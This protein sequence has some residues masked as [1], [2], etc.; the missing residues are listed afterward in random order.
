MTSFPDEQPLTRR[1][2]RERLRAQQAHDG[3][4][5]PKS[6]D[7]D[8]APDDDT[9]HNAG[10]DQSHRLSGSVRDSE[11]QVEPE[12]DAPDG[13]G[14]PL[15][16][17][18]ARAQARASS[19]DAQRSDSTKISSAK[20]TSSVDREE[21]RS[22]EEP[23]ENRDNPATEED[24]S[25]AAFGQK[26][27]NKAPAQAFESLIAPE[28]RPSDALTTSSALVLPGAARKDDSTPTTGD[29]LVTGSVD[30]HR[31][32]EREA[33]SGKGERL[34]TDD[35]ADNGPEANQTAGTPVSA[36]KAVSTHSVTRDVITPQTKTSSSKLLMILA[37]TAGV[38]CVA[39]IGVVIVG[40]MTGTF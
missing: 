7:S 6:G 32:R 26:S 15:T 35:G 11:N 16:R 1:E 5:K 18:Q 20:Q 37:I 19:Q 24:T 14:P 9:T 27:Q 25:P 28:A 13:D 39:V 17:R 4:L 2:L 21:P 8:A 34:E 22:S 30:V 12:G 31:S 3:A 23:G 40:L 29:V 36:T 38:L 33:D 10:Q